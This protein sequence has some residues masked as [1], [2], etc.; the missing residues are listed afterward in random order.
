MDF[1]MPSVLLPVANAGTIMARIR[2]NIV[3]NS[4][5]F[6]ISPILSNCL[7]EPEAAKQFPLPPHPLP[8]PIPAYTRERRR[9]RGIRWASW[10]H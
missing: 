9:D 3:R 8:T 4:T 10:D 1:P 5:V 2:H 6:A 7:T